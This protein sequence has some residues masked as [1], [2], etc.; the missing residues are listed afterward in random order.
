M[1]KTRSFLTRCTASFRCCR[2][3]QYVCIQI[4]WAL[5]PVCNF[6]VTSSGISFS[7]CWLWGITWTMASPRLIRPP[8][9]KLIFSMRWALQNCCPL[10]IVE[11]QCEPQSQCMVAFPKPFKMVY[12]MTI[13]LL[14][15]WSEWQHDCCLF[16]LLAQ[17]NQNCGWEVHLSAHSCQVTLSTLS[18]GA[19]LCQGTDNR[20]P[21]SQRYGRRR[22][23]TPGTRVSTVLA[24]IQC[25]ASL[26]NTFQKTVGSLL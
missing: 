4:H 11:K 22:T 20:A 16:R 10:N 19:G 12:I 3:T 26:L 24:H 23:G 18:R 6:L 25:W 9:L 17:H 5:K 15:G 8:G 1:G 14:P 21:G 2:M 7:L 13:S